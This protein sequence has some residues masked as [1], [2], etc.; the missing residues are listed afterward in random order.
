MFGLA[1]D[2]V[3]LLEPGK[4]DRDLFKLH[5]GNIIAGSTGAAV[6]AN[7]N[8]YIHTVGGADVCRLHVHTS[9]FPVDARV[10]VDKNGQMITVT[11]VNA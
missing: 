11:G 5:L 4:D 8:F 7:V 10:A 2:Y 9:G 6:A 1:N 3:S